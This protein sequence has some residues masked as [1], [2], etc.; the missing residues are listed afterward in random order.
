MPAPG[1]PTARLRRFVKVGLVV[2]LL[3][4]VLPLSASG[5]APGR[6]PGAEPAA[7][8]LGDRV[9]FGAYVD[10]MTHDPALLDGFEDLVGHDAGIASYY[11][12]YGDVFPGP[13]ELAFADGGR[14]RVLL[15]WDM[16]PTRFASWSNGEHD[17][18]LD[19]LVAAA[20]A[21]PYDVYVRPW[22]EMNGDWQTF[23]PTRPGAAPREHGG[24][25][26][27]FKK[28]WRHVVTY[29]RARGADNVKWVFNPTTDVY[30][31]TT[32]VRRIWPGRRYVD[33]LGLDGFNWGSDT[34]WGRWQGFERIFGPQ[35]DRLTRLHPTA[36]VWV[37]EVGS[38][39]PRKDD[40]APADSSRS[41]A[42]WVRDALAT[43]RF[44]RIEALV[45]FQADKERDW[46]VDSSPGSLRALREGL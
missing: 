35:Y 36:P 14:R 22:P 28:A 23:Q 37:C 20:R 25:Y 40:G 6:Q 29:F 4:G 12:G 15:S 43:R 46:R 1:S 44:P 2:L 13:T 17:A 26:A 41:K 11:W 3:L 10:G 24:S 16:G 8:K 21:Y 34:T 45:W 7:R 39:E 5:L 30:A 27:E 18:Y 32:D 42:Q 33:V 31:E 9:T 38:K 19:T